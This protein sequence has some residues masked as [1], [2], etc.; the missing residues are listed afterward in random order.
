MSYRSIL[1]NLDIDGPVVPAAKCA[2]V[3][4]TATALGVENDAGA[5]GGAGA[6][7]VLPAA[8][9]EVTR[10]YSRVDLEDLAATLDPSQIPDGFD[11]QGTVTA[12]EGAFA[13][14]SIRAR[15]PL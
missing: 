14:A 1:V 13:S 7:V 6:T 8:S 3:S 2:T 10:T 12:L 9:V 4:S 15:K 11:V 5:A